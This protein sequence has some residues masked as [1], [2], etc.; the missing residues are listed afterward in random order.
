MRSGA[1]GRNWGRCGATRSVVDQEVNGAPPPA[2]R[3]TQT[4]PS[5]DHRG[6]TRGPNKCFFCIR[7]FNLTEQSERVCPLCIEISN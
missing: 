6:Q 4:L 1:R 3:P 7:C 2:P 5:R